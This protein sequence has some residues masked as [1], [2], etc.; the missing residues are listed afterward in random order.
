MSFCNICVQLSFSRWQHWVAG[1]QAVGFTSFWR[2]TTPL[3]WSDLYTQNRNN[4]MCSREQEYELNRKRRRPVNSMPTIYVYYYNNWQTVVRIMSFQILRQVYYR[5]WPTARCYSININVLIQLK[6]NKV[7]NSP[8]VIRPLTHDIWAHNYTA[9]WLYQGR[10]TPSFV[11]KAKL[12]KESTDGRERS[13]SW[14]YDCEVI[15]QT[16]NRCTH[17]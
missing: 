8:D 1:R 15:M 12:V 10:S 4:R 6:T 16:L 13:D 9:S 3:V 14:S 11:L 7:L 5:C 2:V 17:N